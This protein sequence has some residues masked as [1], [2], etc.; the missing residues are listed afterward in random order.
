MALLHQ[1]AHVPDVVN[2]LLLERLGGHLR[3]M[4]RKEKGRGLNFAMVPKRCVS[5]LLSVAM[6]PINVEGEEEGVGGQYDTTRYLTAYHGI[7]RC[8]WHVSQDRR[9]R[10]M[11][12]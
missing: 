6:A 5:V 8:R 11:R 2:E 7:P 3:R 1:L 10:K 4:W 12:K 9:G